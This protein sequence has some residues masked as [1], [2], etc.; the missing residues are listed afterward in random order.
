MSQRIYCISGL[1]ADE[2]IFANLKIPGR[3]LV[4]IPWLRP[5]K[6]EKIGDYARRMA[7]S[8]RDPSPVLIGVSFGGMMSI[9]IARQFQ[10]ERIFIISS[11]KQR[12]EMPAWMK[13]TGQ[14]QLNKFLPTKSN[15][16]TEGIDN[17]KLGVSSEREKEMVR[18]YRKTAD[19]VYMNWAINEVLNWKNE[20]IPEKL[21][22]IHGTKDN[23]FPVKMIRNAQL[24]EGGT[25][26][27]IYNRAPDIAA[28][29]SH[30]LDGKR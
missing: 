20:W 29:I 14:L 4:H 5:E 26:L 22:H 2:K 24:I 30:E 25:H 6:K 3:E 17:R 15:S 16:L 11:V 10:L 8:L 18:Y 21:V 27:M 19:A 7:A 28:C 23:M 1:G 9:E 13:W 12:A